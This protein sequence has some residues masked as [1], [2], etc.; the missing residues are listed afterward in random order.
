MLQKKGV[1]P[2]LFI[3]IFATVAGALLLLFFILW[4]GQHATTS[5][6]VEDIEFLRSL[7]QQISSLSTTDA[8]SKTLIFPKRLDVHIDCD[9]FFT[10][11]AVEQSSLFLFSPALLTGQQ[12]TL[13]GL[14]WRFP[15]YLDTF[16][17]LIPQGSLVLLFYD[18]AAASFVTSLDLPSTMPVKS[19]PLSAYSLST[20]KQQLQG[21]SRVTLVFFGGSPDTSA[22]LAALRPTPITILEINLQQH[23][24]TF[25]PSGQQR[26]YFGD[27]LLVG[28]F[29]GPEQY[30]CHSQ[31]ALERFRMMAALYQQKVTLLQQKLGAGSSCTRFFS[32]ANSLLTTLFTTKDTDQLHALV[33]S[34]QTLQEDLARYDCPQ[35]Y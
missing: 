29:F 22:L 34:L 7:E 5:T 3:W 20:L 28:A 17:Y 21:Y 32:Q 24:L 10:D 33:A 30:A 31:H 6:T 11:T 19:L 2:D 4:S 15:F 12:Y 27:A 16:Y 13:V 26:P 35:I 14:P 9:T 23:L 18:P 8:L 1:S 25:Y